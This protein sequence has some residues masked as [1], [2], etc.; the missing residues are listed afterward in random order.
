M[1]TMSEVRGTQTMEADQWNPSFRWLQD[2]QD[3]IIL[4]IAS[5]PAANVP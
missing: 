5:N 2:R 3:D 1:R 4:N